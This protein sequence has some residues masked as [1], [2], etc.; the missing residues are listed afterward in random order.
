MYAHHQ[1]LRAEEVQELRKQGGRFLKQLRDARGL[2]Q[3]QLA[4]LVGAEYYTFISQLETGRGR[5]PP[6]RYDAWAEALGVEV[7]R[8]VQDIMRFYDP[9]TYKILFGTGADPDVQ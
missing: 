2:S 4:D 9:V 7:K 8:F 3:K 1:R 5:V 6:D